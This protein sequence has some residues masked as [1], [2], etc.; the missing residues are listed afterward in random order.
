MVGNTQKIRVRGRVQGVGF[1]PFVWR[2][3]RRFCLDGYVLN[4][5]C[6]VLILI[7][8]ENAVISAFLTALETETPPLAR[9][10]AVEVQ[11]SDENLPAGFFITESLSGRAG[12]EISP[13]FAT[14]T[15]CRTET[16]SSGQRRSG[17]AFTNCTHCGPR[18]SIIR[19]LPYDRPNTTMRAFPLCEACTTE[20]INPEDRRFHAEPI[21]CPVCGPQLRLARWASQRIV[22]EDP[23]RAAQEALRAGEI[24][25]IKALGGYQLAVEAT[26]PEAV[27]R[28]RAGKKRD[29][30]PF[31]LMARDIAGIAAHA[32][33]HETEAVALQSR[34]APIL[35]LRSKT[36]HHLAEE[37]A[38]G[39][40]TLGF[41]LP[42]NPLHI[43]L[44][45][46]LDRP[47]VMTSGNLSG[48]PQITEDAEAQEKLGGLA[49]FSL[50]H[51]RAIANR[52]DDSVAR[53]VGGRLRLIRRARGYAPAALPLPPGLENAPDLTAYGADLKSTFCLI[54]GGQAVL[55]AH[56][57]DLESAEA[58]ADFTSNLGLYTGLYAHQPTLIAADLHEGYVSTRL[59]TAAAE[60]ARIPLLCVQHHHAHLAA[61][62]GENQVPHGER[63]MGITL[64]GLG[65]GEEGTLWGAE[66]LLGSYAEVRRVGGLKPSPLPGGDA[67]SREPWRNLYAALTTHTGWSTA[68]ARLAGQ[69]VLTKLEGK[70]LSLLDKM[71]STGLN[72]PLSS[73]CG[74]LFD[75][76]AA[77]LGCGFER[78]RFEGEAAMK[79][80]ALCGGA[81]EGDGYCFNV[82]ETDGF[83]TL[84]PGPFWHALLEDIAA[85]RPRDAMARDFHAGLMAGLC[86]LSQRISKTLPARPNVA[87]S[88]GSFQNRLLF[89]G[90]VTR[91]EA[92]GF[93][94][95]TH[96][97]LPTNDGGIAFG[98]ALVAAARNLK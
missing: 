68:R 49:G 70:P 65:L 28:L 86:A 21:A 83:L 27:A 59:A 24:I 5:H 31:A 42:S 81:A 64:D 39:L 67:A 44:F 46:E 91:L 56:Q 53:E 85:N 4:D 75:A 72:A 3:A 16:L 52:I 84:D 11:A 88:G 66:I 18:L 33:V 61:V 25:A 1:R 37:V 32:H 34:E 10:S 69:E 48:D 40:E 82:V 58:I 92:L 43:L 12:T 20:Y 55:S 54:A 47:L 35:L 96:S 7:R 71:I 51:D 8:G 2:L 63:V 60:A 74:R 30:K 57:G 13:D 22:S 23:I 77:A 9:I 78:Q 89:E 94:V 73:S 26:N 29:G 17:Y 80:E 41:M 79:L 98:Q 76:V 38:P 87:L 36:P 19:T 45:E 93:R 97:I 95:L 6:G 90:M 14:C 50:T 15:D 62:M